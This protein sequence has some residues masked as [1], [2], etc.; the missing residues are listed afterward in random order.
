MRHGG[1][2]SLCTQSC[3]LPR[4]RP[5]SYINF[6]IKFRSSLNALKPADVI[7]LE[8]IYTVDLVEQMQQLLPNLDSREI[9][10]NRR[11]Y[12]T[13]TWNRRPARER[14]PLS[15]PCGL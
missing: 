7:A 14:A 15:K 2:K 4:E 5:W 3:H 11:M 8:P 12:L 10:L 13:N 1:R 6:M 9:P